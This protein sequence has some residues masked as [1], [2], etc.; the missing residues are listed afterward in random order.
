MYN[1]G[2]K[3]VKKNL[4]EFMRFFLAL[5]VLFFKSIRIPFGEIF[6]ISLDGRIPFLAGIIYF[7]Q[8][9]TVVLWKMSWWN[10]FMKLLHVIAVEKHLSDERTFCVLKDTF[11]HMK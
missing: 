1:Y 11:F 7:W 3:V 10:E 9:A 8:I 2:S 4:S 6:L 5:K